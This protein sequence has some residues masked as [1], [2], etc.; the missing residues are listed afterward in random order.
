MSFRDASGLGRRDFLRRVGAAAAGLIVTRI[1]G[2]SIGEVSGQD[3]PSPESPAGGN[4]IDAHAHAEPE[5]VKKLLEVMDDN[6]ISFAVLMGIEGDERFHQYLEAVRPYK[7]RF[8]LMYALDWELLRTDSKFFEKAPGLLERAV[9]AG[10]LGLKNFKN[11]GLTVRDG[12]GDLL[13]ID[14]PRLFPIWERAERLGCPVAFHTGDP[15]AFFEPITPQNER[16]EELRLHPEWSFA[17]RSRYPERDEIL[18]QRNNVI[19]RFRTVNFVCVHGAGKPEDI[20]TIARWLK[21]MPNMQAD[22]S[23]RLGE[24][25]RLPADRVHALF[26]EFQDRWLFGTDIY[27]RREGIIQGAGPCRDF[28]RAE[29]KRFYRTHWR[30]FQ[31]RDLR[32]DHPTPIQGRWKINGVGLDPRVCRKL[33][34]GNASRLY[35]L[36]PPA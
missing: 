17:D 2:A 15:K 32:F 4:A 16:Y 20:D 9:H 30:Y 10:A 11:L 22:T 36:R 33:Y 13:R 24:L 26:T 34:F 5:S 18:E 35:C 31:T 27:A 14:E 1:P 6:S 8:G 25:G 28:T 7:N 12:R 3:G 29:N 19:R 23:A 21:D